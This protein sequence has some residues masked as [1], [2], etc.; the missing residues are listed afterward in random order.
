VAYKS[1]TPYV[2]FER[3]VTQFS[4]EGNGSDK[5]TS[6]RRELF[7]GRHYTLIALPG[8]KGGTRLE[9]FSD[10]LGK[11][12][13]N[14]ARVRLINATTSGD[15]LNLYVQGT[16]TRILRGSDSGE[17]VAVAEMYAATVEIR[18]ER[19]SVTK[20]FS[21]LTVDPGRLYTFI[22]VNNGAALDVVQIEDR[23]EP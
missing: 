16:N 13:P 18:P 7:P 14:Q 15:E 6:A 22:A 23:V 10:D 17:I 19:K 21:D 8:K 20:A 1:I 4:T 12:D 2:E 3:G 5:S 11:L 9:T